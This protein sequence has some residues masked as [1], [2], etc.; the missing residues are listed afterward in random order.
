MSAAVDFNLAIVWAF[1][2]FATS[3]GWQ[4]G[5]G[6]HLIVADWVRSRDCNRTE[7]EHLRSNQREGNQIS[8]IISVLLEESTSAVQGKSMLLSYRI[9]IPQSLHIRRSA[10]DQSFCSPHLMQSLLPSANADL[11]QL[12]LPPPSDIFFLLSLIF[13]L[14]KLS[15]NWSLSLAN[16]FVPSF[17]AYFRLNIRHSSKWQL[18]DKGG[19]KVKVSWVESQLTSCQ[20]LQS[21]LLTFPAPS[22]FISIFSGFVTV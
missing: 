8:I 15:F 17:Y 9:S 19:G 13:P 16:Q 6:A 20:R 21:T 10:A 11:A 12:T 5:K 7:S 1:F 18:R 3:A 2:P 4:S 14:P 22:T